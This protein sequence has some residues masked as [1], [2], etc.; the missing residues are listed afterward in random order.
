MGNST[1]PT[2]LDKLCMV[3]NIHTRK[4][5]DVL[6]DEINQR[7]DRIMFLQDRLSA[8][9]QIIDHSRTSL[10]NKVIKNNSFPYLG[11]NHFGYG[12]NNNIK[13]NMQEQMVNAALTI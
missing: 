12:M 9:E 6:K 13:T 1:L 3:A 4:L 8:L 7:N 5:T 10:T 2:V 11:T